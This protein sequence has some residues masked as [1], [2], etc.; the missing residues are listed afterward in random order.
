MALYILDYTPFA[1]ALFASTV[2]EWVAIL[3]AFTPL[4]LFA[5]ASYLWGPK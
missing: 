4:V 2:P 1:T 3:I 5:I